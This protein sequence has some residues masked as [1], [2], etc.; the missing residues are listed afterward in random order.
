[1]S[2][3]KESLLVI[4]GMN[5][6]KMNEIE[7]SIDSQ[8]CYD[9]SPGTRV[10][11]YN[12]LSTINPIIKSTIRE[13]RNSLGWEVDYED[14]QCDTPLCVYKESNWHT[15]IIVT[16]NDDLEKFAK[17]DEEAARSNEIVARIGMAAVIIVILCG[18]VYFCFI[19]G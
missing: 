8:L 2:A 6:V 3:T 18:I 1:M 16:H 17:L 5:R 11:V 13:H 10:Y 12:H 7:S 9:W 19:R 14:W 4:D 15:K